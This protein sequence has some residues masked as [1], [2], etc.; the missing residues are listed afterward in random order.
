MPPVLDVNN[1]T[2]RA[3]P[4]N[5]QAPNG[6]TRV[7]ITFRIKDDNSGYEE[8]E[9]MLR[10]PNGGEHFYRHYDKDF[11]KIYFTRDPAVFVTYVH[12]ITLPAGSIPGTWGLA[13]MVVEDKALNRFKADFTEIVRFEV[14]DPGD[15]PVVLTTPD[16]DFN[17]TVDFSENAGVRRFGNRNRLHKW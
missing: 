2:I 14:A 11:G 5:P 6:E 15:G 10:D 13:E 8:T 1:V 4:T 7:Y 9:M 17:G 12:L 16:F 3:T